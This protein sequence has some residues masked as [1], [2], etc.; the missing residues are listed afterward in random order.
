LIGLAFGG[1]G[2]LEDDGILHG[3]GGLLFAIVLEKTELGFVGVELVFD[4]LD[5]EREEREIL[6]SA[7]QVRAGERA[8]AGVGSGSSSGASAS[9]ARAKMPCSMA[10]ARSRRQMASAI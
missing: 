2:A 5:V 3:L 4:A 1:G 6:P 8:G 9:R 7:S 10:E